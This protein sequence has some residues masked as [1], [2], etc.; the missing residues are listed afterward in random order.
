MKKVKNTVPLTYVISDLNRDEIVGKFYEKELQ[1]TNQKVFKVSY[2]EAIK[3]KS[4]KL[5]VKWKEYNNWF[6]SWVDKKDILIISG[7][8][9][10]H[11]SSRGRVKVELNLSNYATKIDFKKATGVDISD[12]AKKLIYLI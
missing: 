3:R 1:K 12:F 9:P 6:N 5:Y 8:F 10:E 11:K 2:K 7:Y 4:V